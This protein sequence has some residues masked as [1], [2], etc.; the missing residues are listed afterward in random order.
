VV[1][2]SNVKICNPLETEEVSCE[3]DVKTITVTLFKHEM[4]GSRTPIEVEIELEEGIDIEDVIEEKCCE[5]FNN[6]PQFKIF[7]EEDDENITHKFFYTIRSRGRGIHVRFNTRIQFFK[8]YK[9]FPVLPPYFRTLIFFPIVF[10]QYRFDGRAFTRVSQIGG[11]NSTIVRGPHRVISAGFFG[12]SW[13]IGKV[14]LS[15]FIVRKGFVGV[16]VFTRIV[17]L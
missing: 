5:I 11:N 1:S 17:K 8:L 4:D 15:G 16:S 6:D 10:C 14:S 12:I 2:G 3:K 7:E 9:L 13:W